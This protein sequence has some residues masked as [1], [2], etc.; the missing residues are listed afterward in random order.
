MFI[1]QAPH[2]KIETTTLLPN[3]QFSDSE[4]LAA[5]VTRKL[6]MDATRYIYVK[7]KDRRTLHWSFK[8][9]RNKA[10]ELRAFINAY[11]AQ[12]ILVK[13]HNDRVW[14]GNFASNPFEFEA[15][16]RSGPAIDGWAVGESVRVELVFEGVE[17]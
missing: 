10:L 15:Y 6:A 7:K 2:P 8:L 17:Q 4:G 1:I 14:L 9:T 12:K 13:D 11:F 3:P 16:E 5:T